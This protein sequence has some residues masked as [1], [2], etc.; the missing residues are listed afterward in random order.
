MCMGGMGVGE[1]MCIGVWGMY[2]PLKT[3]KTYCFAR[4]TYSRQCSN[5]SINYQCYMG[6]VLKSGDGVDWPN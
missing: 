5:I 3:L 4:K 1:V 6:G 2:V